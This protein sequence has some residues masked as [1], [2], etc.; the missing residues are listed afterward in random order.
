MIII[1]TTAG[2]IWFHFWHKQRVPAS[3][4]SD[5]EVARMARSQKASEDLLLVSTRLPA[6]RRLQRPPHPWLRDDSG[7]NVHLESTSEHL[8]CFCVLAI[9]NS[10]AVNIVVHISF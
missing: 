1:S 2:T 3:M 10:C 8:G 7:T 4:K 6:N 5:R 9:V